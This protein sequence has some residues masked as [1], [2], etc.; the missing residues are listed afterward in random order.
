MTT[1]HTL[2]DFN[3]DHYCTDNTNKKAKYGHEDHGKVFP[4]EESLVLKFHDA[5]C[6]EDIGE[7]SR[8]D[9]ALEDEQ[10]REI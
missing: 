2:H 3:D 9:H 10:E 5:Q 6:R 7:R 1:V 4:A 8:V